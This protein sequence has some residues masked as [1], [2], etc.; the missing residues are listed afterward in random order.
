VA[1]DLSG[2][3]GAPLLFVVVDKSAGAKDFTWNMK[4]AGGAGAAKIEGNTVLVGNPAAENLKCAFVSSK[5]LTLTGAIS[6]AGADE[7]FA[8][9]T[10]QTG[11]APEMKVEGEGLAAK[12]SIGG[13]TVRLDGEKIALGK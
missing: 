13:Q 3:C 2:A 12:V 6:A 9:I 11:A 5:A 8:V 1:L 10:V 7:Y 4:L